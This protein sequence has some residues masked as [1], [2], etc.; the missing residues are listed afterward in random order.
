MNV[1]LLLPSAF[2]RWSFLFRF[3]FL[4]S[5]RRFGSVRVM[6]EAPID[7]SQR[8]LGGTRKLT[9]D[10]P[11]RPTQLGGNWIL[12]QVSA[13]VAAKKCRCK[14]DVIKNNFYTL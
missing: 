4:E 13:G 2:C 8:C 11:L 10:K 7:E 3:L 6:G 12:I 9:L 5:A 14:I 1:V